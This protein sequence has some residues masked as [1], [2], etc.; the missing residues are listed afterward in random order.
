M[1]QSWMVTVDG[2]AYGPYPLEQMKTFIAEGRVVAHSLVGA[3][4]EAPHPADEDPGLAHLFQPA[5]PRAAA[6]TER[7]VP[8]EPAAAQ[9][10]GRHA[11]Q[12]AGEL[13]HFVIMADM[14]SHSINGLEEAIFNLGQ[15]YPLL[16]QAWLL[17]S[18]YPLNAIRNTLVQK[19][20]TLDMLF[21]VDATHDKSAW[22]NFGPE[23]D[24]RIRR[25]WNKLSATDRQAG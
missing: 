14:K 6:V 18:T 13:S 5:R 4:G 20:G 21:I 8:A 15:G 12:G 11:E 19:L 7:L 1:S 3:P 24:T 10:F 22:F 16:P 2:Q 25:I 23:A 17:T 9:K